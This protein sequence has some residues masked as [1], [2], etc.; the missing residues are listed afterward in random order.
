MGAAALSCQPS[1]FDA[2]RQPSRNADPETSHEAARELQTSG[3]LTEQCEQTL[4]ALVRWEFRWA[5]APTSHELAAGDTDL[6][7]LYARRL[8]D[9]SKTNPQ[10]VTQLDSKRPCRVTGRAAF[11]WRVTE[12]GMRVFRAIKARKAKEEAA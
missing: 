6:R 12:E 8:P 4:A 7:Y 11:P 9:L 10:L 2:I 5:Y 1:L 3:R